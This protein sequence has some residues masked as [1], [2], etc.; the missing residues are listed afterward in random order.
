MHLKETVSFKELF[1]ALTY[2]HTMKSKS[3][4]GL[5][6]G[7]VI[8]KQQKKLLERVSGFAKES[9]LDS[10]NLIQKPFNARIV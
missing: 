5:P 4:Q 8:R 2:P 10:A 3:Q 7:A 9:P 6:P 1:S